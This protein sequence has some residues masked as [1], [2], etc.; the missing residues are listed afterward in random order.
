MDRDPNEPSLAI[1]IPAAGA[2]MLMGIW[3]NAESLS[4]EAGVAVPL[5]A[6]F[7]SFFMKGQ[8][9]KSILMGLSAGFLVT[10]GAFFLTDMGASP[11]PLPPQ[12]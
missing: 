12:P 3:A 11:R 10:Y 2:G 6:F 4:P 8:V 1:G 9:S 7:A 5:F